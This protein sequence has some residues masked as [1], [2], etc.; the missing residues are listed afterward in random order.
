MARIDAA[1]VA[2][3]VGRL[4]EARD[5]EPERLEPHGALVD[6]FPNGYDPDQTPAER[7]A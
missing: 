7:D 5:A 3:A 4:R 6:D 2:R 1:S